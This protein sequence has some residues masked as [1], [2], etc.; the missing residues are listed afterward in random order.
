MASTPK[1]STDVPSIAAEAVLAKSDFDS[2]NATV[3]YG[4]P[5]YFQ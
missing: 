3:K 2:T 4:S 1:A 5:F